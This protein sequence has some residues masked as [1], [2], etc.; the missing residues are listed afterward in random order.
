MPFDS[1]D[2]ATNS[3]R[4]TLGDQDQ[5]CKRQQLKH[6][7]MCFFKGYFLAQRAFSLQASLNKLS[8]L[9]ELRLLTLTDPK[10]PKKQAMM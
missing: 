8:G 3:D 6:V 1:M 2:G 7:W 10:N 4:L 9:Q 5:R